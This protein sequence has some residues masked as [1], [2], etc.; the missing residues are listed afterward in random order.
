MC[1]IIGVTGRIDSAE[2]V[3]E[4]LR[5]LEYRG[6]DSAGVAVSQNGKISRVRSEGKIKNLEKVLGVNPL[7]SQLAIGHTR[8]AT[9]G[10]PSERNAHPH[11]TDKVAVVHNGIIENYLHIR[12]ELQKLGAEFHSETDTE[13]IPHLITKYLNDG[14]S[15]KEAVI[16]AVH[17]LEGAYALGIIFADDD[18]TI[19]AT[20]HG[21]PLVVGYGNSENYIASDALALAPL[22]SKICYLEEGDIAEITPKN[23][24]IYNRKGEEVARKIQQSNLSAI[25]IGKENYRHFMQK[26]IF[27][28]PSVIG[29][30]F[31]AYFN[32]VQNTIS[33]PNLPFD[34]SE[35]SAVTIIGCGTSY[36]AG[37]VAT[38]WFERLAKIQAT[39]EVASEF[40]YR[41]AI[42][43][44]NG[45]CIFLSQSGETADT[46]AALKYAKSQGQKTIA[47]VNVTQSSIAREADYVLPIYSGPEIGVA[48]TKAF[49][50][51]LCTLAFL[52]LKTAKKKNPSQVDLYNNSARIMLEIP[53]L[54]SQILESDKHIE[55]IAAELSGY[56]DILYV[57]RGVSYPI[58]MEGALK[59][60]EISYIHSEATA[61][62]ELKHGPIALID[63]NVPVV[64]IAPTDELFDKTASNIR[65]IA[66]RGGKIILISDKLGIDNLKDVTAHAIEMP[67]IDCS[68]VAFICQ[69][70][71]PIIYSVPVQLLAYYV[72]V[73]KGTD[74]DQPRN[75]AKSVTVE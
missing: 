57:G 36:Y 73:A 10:A 5:R 48:S 14:N 33:M 60:K 64:A 66:A 13:I 24:I 26:E 23:I 27:E 34:L 4:G 50:T 72:A 74:V 18:K 17:R 52:M 44:K 63:E 58:A 37:K 70:I 31:H 25:N 67:M 59:L 2:I 62:G 35:I 68:R 7:K 11:A 43:Q 32:G 28:Q 42:L 19:F 45:M 71:S 51:Q 65:E 46:L 1:G 75:L 41:E 69:I 49:T 30:N 20:R 6:Y 53:S 16:K 8:W 21:A 12:A 39:A 56:R 22:T 40:R 3:V 55:K 29:D 54:I 61:A 47:I 38:Y 15:K 9:H